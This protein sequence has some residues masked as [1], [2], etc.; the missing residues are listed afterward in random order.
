M[1]FGLKNL[2]RRPKYKNQQIFKLYIM[3]LKENTINRLKNSYGNWVLITGATSGI[4]KALAKKIAEAGFNLIIT[5]R[6]LEALQELEDQFR[7]KEKIDVLAIKG[8][9]SNEEDIYALIHKTSN[10]PIG[11]AI[12]NAG[13]GTSGEFYQNNLLEEVS[14]L[15]VNCKA[16][17]ILSH[18]FANKMISQKKGAIVFLSS[19]VGFQGV[20]Y[21]ANYAATKAYIQTLGEALHLEFKT[22]GV[23]VLCA[24][25]GPVRSGFEE[26]ANMKMGNSLSPEDVAVPIIRSIGKKSQVFPG[27]LTK[28]L[29]FNL[30]LVPRFAKI[31]IMRKVMGGFTQHQRV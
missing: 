1:T 11:I 27:F 12:L 22:K 9:L 28:F 30:K 29:M 20:P 25:P 3:L 18:H 26:R 14:M 16:P 8:D 13:Y 17:L 6:N 15:H 5:G 21:A 4:G 31:R 19:I 23:T 7:E 10:Y 24:A 2:K